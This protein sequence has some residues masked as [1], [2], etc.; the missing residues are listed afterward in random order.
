MAE[1]QTHARSFGS[2]VLVSRFRGFY[3]TDQW[4]ALVPFFRLSVGSEFPNTLAVAIGHV[5]MIASPTE[6]VGILKGATGND[7]FD[8]FRFHVDPL[9]RRVIGSH[10]P[11]LAVGIEGQASGIEP[12]D[13]FGRPVIN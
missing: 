9:N 2:S 5:A 13:Q 6:P 8:L 4:V 10:R 11:Q 3:R 7:L 12:R 1:Y